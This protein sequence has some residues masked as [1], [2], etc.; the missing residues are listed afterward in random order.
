[1]KAKADAKVAAVQAKPAGNPA[2]KAVDLAE[3]RK[4][5]NAEKNDANY[6]AAKERC[7]AMSGN[8]KSAC[9]DDIK[10][11]YGKG[12]SLPPRNFSHNAPLWRGFFACAGRICL[13]CINTG[14]QC[15]L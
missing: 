12:G 15:G 7:D 10:R 1:M 11:T 6:Q 2:E 4:E 3:T 9:V 14:S 13:T 5:A 8:A